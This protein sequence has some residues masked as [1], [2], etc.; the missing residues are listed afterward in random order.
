MNETGFTTKRLDLTVTLG[1][2]TF[3]ES[4]ADT[5]TLTGFRMT[6]Q[7]SNPGGESMGMCQ[8]KV[9]GLRTDVINKLTTIGQINRAI[10]VKNAIL[11]AAGDNETGMQTVF[12]GTIY[13]AWA[14]YNTSPDVSFNIIAYMGLDAAVRPVNASSYKGATDVATIMAAFAAEMQLT[15]E[16]NGVDVKLSNPYFPGTALTKVRQCARAANILF[17]VDRGVLAI[18]PKTGARA[19]FVPLISPDSGMVGYPSLSSKGMTVKMLF[20][21][22]IRLGGEVMVESS[23][24]MACGKWNVFSVAHDLS[25]EMP[26]GP[27]FTQMDC[28]HVE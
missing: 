9:F 6:A 19:G 3:G 5:V 15:F 18:W 7:I 1:A 27:W 2:G 12:Q 16:N 20:N 22:N 11:L 28:Y 24:P 4:L 10:K 17:T 14:D 13:D 26:D 8:M 25:C 23:V 21:Y